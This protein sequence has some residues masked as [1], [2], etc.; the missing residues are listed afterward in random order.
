MPSAP[1]LRVKIADDGSCG[2]P[3][4]SRGSFRAGGRL[5]PDVRTRDNSLPVSSVTTVVSEGPSATTPS[6]LPRTGVATG[7]AGGAEPTAASGTTTIASGYDPSVAAT[8]TSASVGGTSSGCA[9]PAVVEAIGEADSSAR[10][11]IG[12]GITSIIG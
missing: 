10:T 9:A 12:S 6:V 8:I 7:A 4:Q 3:H 2:L 5:P 11:N 1:S